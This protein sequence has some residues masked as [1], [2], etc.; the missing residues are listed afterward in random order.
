MLASYL[1]PK[2]WWPRPPLRPVPGAFDGLVPAL[3]GSPVRR[4][5]RRLPH[6]VGSESAPK[7][8]RPGRTRHQ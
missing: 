2:R 1:P 7:A 8:N 5:D 4:S 6:G 3:R